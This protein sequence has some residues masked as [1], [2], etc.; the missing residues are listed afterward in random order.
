MY[1]EMRLQASCV[2]VQNRLETVFEGDYAASSALNQEWR[3]AIRKSLSTPKYECATVLLWLSDELGSPPDSETFPEEIQRR[4]AENPLWIN[5]YR[6]QWLISLR[7][8]LAGRRHA[9]HYE[10]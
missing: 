2:L 8:T 4:S 5:R 7:D 3:D 1:A 9:T 10:E 6:A